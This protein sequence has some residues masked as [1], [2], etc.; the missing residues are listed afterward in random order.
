[1]IPLAASHLLSAE[2]GTKLPFPAW[3]FGVI[4]FAVLVALLL[5]LLNFDRDR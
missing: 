2:E 4:A 3:L 5:V 1:M